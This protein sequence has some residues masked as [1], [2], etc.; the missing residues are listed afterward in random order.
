MLSWAVARRVT[1]SISEGSAKDCPARADLRK[2][3]HQPSWRFNQQAATGMK[4]CRIRGW[5]S[6]HVRVALLLWEVSIPSFRRVLSY[7]A[8]SLAVAWPRCCLMIRSNSTGGRPPAR[9]CLRL[10]L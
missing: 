10:V 2:S 3:R 7:A 1:W 6:N 8:S 5:S 9:L 4:A